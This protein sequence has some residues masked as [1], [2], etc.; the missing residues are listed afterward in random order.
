MYYLFL[1]IIR[2]TGVLLYALT[3]VF[4]IIHYNNSMALI[5]P[6]SCIHKNNN[7]TLHKKVY[8]S[9]LSDHTMSCMFIA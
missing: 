8:R 1:P 4:L 3:N 6:M 7:V 5:L 9:R 2:A